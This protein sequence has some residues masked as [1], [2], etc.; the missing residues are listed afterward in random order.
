MKHFS[1]SILLTVLIFLMTSTVMATNAPRWANYDF[2]IG[3]DAKSLTDLSC[4]I[5]EKR[6]ARDGTQIGSG[7]KTVTYRIDWGT[8]QFWRDRAEVRNHRIGASRM[9]L[10]L[11]AY[12]ARVDIFV[13]GGPS[14]AIVLNLARQD[15]LEVYSTGEWWSEGRG[16]CDCLGRC[17][18]PRPMSHFE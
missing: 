14:V 6:F 8:R 18:W 7:E 1:L 2:R 3:P 15:T 5:S 16:A 13:S 11:Q 10:D 12:H 17:R 9:L 4:K